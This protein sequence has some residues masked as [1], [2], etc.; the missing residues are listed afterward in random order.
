MG[1]IMSLG[2]KQV[3]HIAFVVRDIESVA[4][5]WSSLLGAPMPE[6]RFIPG[7]ETAPTVTDG[8]L[9]QYSGCRLCVIELDN[10]VL[11]LTEPGLEPSPW[12]TFLEKHGEGLMHMAFLVP[13]E[14][15]ALRS[16]EETCGVKG[17]YHIGY[18][19]GQSYSFVDTFD[20]LKTELNIKVNRDNT[21]IIRKLQK[22]LL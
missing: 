12:K 6:I 14:E 13:D 10:L 8:K 1:V 3:V 16:I 11:E 18:Y 5:K 21:E 4:K 17:Y 2:I 20:S 7:A 22:E 9:E 15:E 19:P